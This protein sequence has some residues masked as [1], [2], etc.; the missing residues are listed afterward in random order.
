[1]VKSIGCSSRG[2][3]FGSQ[4]ALCGSSGG[5]QHTH[6]MDRHIHIN[7]TKGLE[8]K[9][10]RMTRQVKAFDTTHDGLTS[11]S[12]THMVEGEK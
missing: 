10:Q 9:A 11:T 2:P 12:W 6:S 7:K 8:L 4:H 5:A 1:M 3:G